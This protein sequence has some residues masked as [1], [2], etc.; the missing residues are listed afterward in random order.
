[1]PSFGDSIFIFVLALVLFGPERL[2][3]LARE[4]GKL[5]AEFRRASNEFK[6]QIEEELR[7]AEQTEQRKKLDAVET[8]STSESVEAIASSGEVSIL[9]PETG[10]PIHAT[11]QAALDAENG[12]D[13]QPSALSSILAPQEHTTPLSAEELEEMQK[14]TEAGEAVPTAPIESLHVATSVTELSPTEPSTEAPLPKHEHEEV[15]S[16]HG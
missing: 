7:M 2:P 14:Q 15:N 16:T 10:L 1:M 3:K 8:T 9:P 4:L 5:M 11:Y 13:S 12:V 6:F